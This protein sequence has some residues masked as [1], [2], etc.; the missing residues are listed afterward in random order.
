MIMELI[1]TIPNVGITFLIII[2]V[3]VF[4]QV[5]I[6]NTQESKR[7]KRILEQMNRLE[8]K[9]EQLNRKEE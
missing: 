9:L 2:L 6:H 1:M 7:Y 8:K 4:F 3:M 5:I